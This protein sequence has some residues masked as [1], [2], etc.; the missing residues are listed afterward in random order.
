MGFLIPPMA[1][2]T[3]SE[4]G[5]A[6]SGATWDHLKQRRELN[7]DRFD[8]NHPLLGGMLVDAVC[9][10]KLPQGPFWD[11]LRA[12]Y[13][14]AP[15]RF[16]KF[17]PFL[18][19]LLERDKLASCEIVPTPPP[20]DIPPPILPPPTPPIPQIPIPE[21]KQPDPPDIPWEPPTVI[22]EPASIVLLAFG[23]G[24]IALYRLRRR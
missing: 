24:S 17:H 9:V 18:G 2:K 8:S 22:P 7:P 23:I 15:D 12:R 10:G 19:P 5:S 13:E 16:T 20:P 3:Y 21:I 4:T 1:L 11:R 14:S 6:P